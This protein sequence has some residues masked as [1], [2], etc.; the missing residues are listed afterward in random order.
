MSR[1]GGCVNELRLPVKVSM[2]MLSTKSLKMPVARSRDAS[3]LCHWPSAVLAGSTMV[4]SGLP[5]PNMTEPAP[6]VTPKSLPRPACSA[7]TRPLPLYHCPLLP[8][9]S[10]V[11]NSKLIEKSS[12]MGRAILTYDVLPSKENDPAL[13]TTFWCD[14]VPSKICVSSKTGTAH[15]GN[16]GPG[17]GGDGWYAGM[18]MWLASEQTSRLAS[19]R[20]F[21]PLESENEAV[22]PQQ[23]YAE[24]EDRSGVPV[25]GLVALL[26]GSEEQTKK[27]SVSPGFMLLV[28]HADPSPLE[29]T[30]LPRRSVS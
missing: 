6:M 14:D 22:R 7:S 1:Y 24:H 2:R 18:V 12:E 17:G 10:V 25:S 21:M 23:P 15:P 29:N 5:M 30:S 11:L 26:R 27:E 28:R 4:V 19:Q 8:R 9:M 13:C 16:E 3:T 20:L